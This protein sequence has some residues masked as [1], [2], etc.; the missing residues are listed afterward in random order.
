VPRLFLTEPISIR[1]KFLCTQS[2]P[3]LPSKSVSV[4]LGR[5]LLFRFNSFG[6]SIFPSAVCS[7]PAT[8]PEAASSA[9]ASFAKLI[10]SSLS[11]SKIRPS[12]SPGAAV[13]I[14]QKAPENYRAQ[15]TRSCF[16]VIEKV[17]PPVHSSLSYAKIN[18]VDCSELVGCVCV[19]YSLATSTQTKLGA[20]NPLTPR[21]GGY[22][23][24][25]NS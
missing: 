5:C 2:S 11:S 20:R 4:N 10:L 3:I 13:C 17:Q 16:K 25:D 18:R 14:L 21:R 15:S 6:S 8:S 23:G 1:G 24:Y 9:P 7:V 19:M 12:R 22:A